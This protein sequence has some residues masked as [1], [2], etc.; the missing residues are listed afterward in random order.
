M[1]ETQTGNVQAEQLG[2]RLRTVREATGL[3]LA[4]C[5]Q[6][7][8]VSEEQYQAFEHG[9]ESPSLPQLEAFAY[10][11]EFLPETLFEGEGDRPIGQPGDQAEKPVLDFGRVAEL[12]RRIIGVTIQRCR[13][14]AGLTLEHL[15]QDTGIAMPVLEKYEFGEIQVPITDLEAIAQKTGHSLRDFLDRKSQLG[16]WAERQR[17]LQEILNLPVDLRDFISKP[18]NRP[19]L[20]IAQRLS[21]MPAAK[22]RNIAEGL[23]E[24]TL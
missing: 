20:E 24:I 2:G 15:A 1:D 23:L 7:M 5:A 17:M 6:V 10:T 9:E 11:V 16:I 19:F 8:G 22:L 18:V 21:E 3:S 12:R 4:A 14:E 13:R